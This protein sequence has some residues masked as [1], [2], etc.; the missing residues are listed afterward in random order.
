MSTG[1]IVIWAL[2]SAATAVVLISSLGVLVMPGVYGRLHFTGPPAVLAPVALAA[3]VI[4]RHGID[5]SSVAGLLVALTL[6][7]TNPVLVHATARA[8]RIHD[9]GGE[10]RLRPSERRN[11]E[12]P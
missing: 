8:V 11:V 3:A 1:D 4:V 2:L 12:E 10:W 5:S 7:V 6:L 9:A